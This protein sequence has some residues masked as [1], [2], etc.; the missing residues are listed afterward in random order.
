MLK[1]SHCTF[2]GSPD[3]V[4]VSVDTFNGSSDTIVG[5]TSPQMGPEAIQKRCQYKFDTLMVSPETPNGVMKT[6]ESCHFDTFL[7]SPQDRKW[8]PKKV[9][10]GV[11][12]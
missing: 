5:I 12:I 10:N 1:V 11:Q 4:L 6:L 3:T 2:N 7:V 9:Y 8:T